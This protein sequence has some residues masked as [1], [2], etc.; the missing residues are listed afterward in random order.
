[1]RVPLS[2]LKEYVDIALPLPEL[3]ERMTLAGLEV[4]AIE[5]IGAEWARDK[6]VVGEVVEVR[7]HPNADRLTIA[8]VD[9]GMGEPE[10][11]VTGAS[12]LKVGD[13]GQKVAFARSGAKLID[14]Y[15]QEKRYITLKPT[16]IR[17]VLSAG[18]VC[19]E[20]E[21]GLSDEHEGIL[22][23]DPDAPVGMPLQD[24]LGDTVLDIDLTPNLGR[25]LSVIGVAREV[26]ALTGQ[27]LRL[28][29]P[30]MKAE[31][32]PIEGQIEIEIADPDL[33]SRYSATLIRGVKIGPSPLW[34]QRRLRMAGMRPINCIVD[35][36]NYVMLEWG[37]PLHAFDYD[38]LRGRK[39]GEKP[40]IIVR[41][42]KPGETIT[43]LDGIERHLEPDMLLITD[44]GGPVA[45]AG[46]MGGLETEISPFTTNVLLESANFNNLN[47]RRTSEMLK[48]P[49]EASLR[50]GRGLPPEVTVIAAQRA[51]ELMRQ[52][53]GGV[54]AAGIADCY[55]VKQE[56]KIIDLPPGEVTRLLGIDLSRQRTVEILRSLGF[57]CETGEGTEPIRVT[58]PYYRLDVE[59]PADLVEE[60]ARVVGYD[61]IPDTLLR[62]ELPPQRRNLSLEGEQRVRDI[63]VGCGLTEVITYSLTNLESVSKLDP[64]R[65]AVNP[66]EYIRLA[67]PLT[68]EREYLRRTL[69]NSL[70]ET[71]R[72]NLRFTERVAIFE[73]ARVY[74]PQPGQDLPEEPRRLGIVM[75][76]PRHPT[77]WTV[78]GEEFLDFYDLKGVAEALLHHLHITGYAF[79]PTEHPTLHTGRAAK[80]VVNDIEI[81]VLGEVHPL[82]RENFDLPAQRVCLLEFDLE[83]LLTL[84][85]SSFY[86]QPISRF[87]AVT[88]DLALIVDDEVPAARVRD[89]IVK[90]GGRLLQKVELFDVYHGAQVP[91][92]KKSL[93]YTL[94][95]QAPDRTLTDDEVNKIQLRIQK[96]LEKELGAQ[97]RA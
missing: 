29:E 40:V 21:L 55:P 46:V 15:S 58:V 82:V 73:V 24:Y 71:L 93:A 90:A 43:T 20:K 74:L 8:V 49:S 92:G 50:F 34:M 51:S 45:I 32:P 5:Q 36:T 1:M 9:H 16:K 11:V 85:P 86:Y 38:K 25:C 13:H 62:D 3:A 22:I 28:T 84:V 30:T 19:S 10:A 37:Q 76:G 68:S 77:S 61:K 47:N 72:D 94:T 41:R 79:V 17:G 7:P 95:Y 91:P 59:M 35:I 14:G 44:G 96:A 87:P 53:A 48:L 65:K 56:V 78:K 42:A 67:N 12:N 4:A 83:A 97:L 89:A 6:I 66:E 80:L 63:L 88:R 69:M 57:S 18:M 70:L 31:G 2:W 33:C 27:E 54:I 26:A 64:T 75:S 60:V 23:L 39:A 52:L 81:G